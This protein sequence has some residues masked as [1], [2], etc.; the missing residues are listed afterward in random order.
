MS[1]SSSPEHAF[2]HD[3]L[4]TRYAFD[5]QARHQG[6]DRQV[7]DQLRASDTPVV[8]DVGAGNGANLRYWVPR[9][10]QA[11]QTWYWVDHDPRLR[12]AAR[13]TL[14]HHLWPDGEVLVQTETKTQIRQRDQVLTVHWCVGSLLELSEMIPLDQV[15]LVTAN[16]V[17]DLFTEDEFKVFAAQ[18]ASHRVPLYATLNYESMAFVP[19]KPGDAWAIRQYEA[20]MRRPQ[21]RGTAMG[22]DCA[23]HMLDI[24]AVEPEAR[25]D[26]GPSYWQMSPQDQAMLGYLL[27]FMGESIPTMLDTPQQRAD[28]DRWWQQRKQDIA[29]ARMGLSVKHQDLLLG[30]KGA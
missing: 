17:F 26:T 21:K 19:T 15:H 5:V 11:Q 27:G 14:H 28:F 6:L 10:P 16:A 29:H 9:L 1:A 18:L 20:H 8:V 30:W 7:H 22:A 3:W 24:W 23:A 12:E 4:D 2:A 25:T 13:Q